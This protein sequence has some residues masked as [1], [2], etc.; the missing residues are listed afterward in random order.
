MPTCVSCACCNGN[1]RT[2]LREYQRRYP[3]R[4]QPITNM[5]V[6]AH[7]SVR[8]VRAFSPP[9]QVSCARSTAQNEEE[10]LNAVHVYPSTSTHQG[11]YETGLCVQFGKQQR[12]T[13]FS[14]T[15]FAREK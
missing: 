13:Y 7:C 2:A 9:S 14:C 1:A 4:W 11:A 5:S 12:V 6:L 8:K 3:D 15:P 10:V